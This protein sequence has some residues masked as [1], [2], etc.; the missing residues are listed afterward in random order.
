MAISLD[1]LGSLDSSSSTIFALGALGVDL[2][3]GIVFDFL[4]V[5]ALG[6]FTTHDL[7]VFSGDDLAFRSGNDRDFGSGDDLGFRAKDDSDSSL[8]SCNDVFLPL[9]VVFLL[10]ATT[11]VRLCFRAV[12]PTGVIGP[13]C[14]CYF[15]T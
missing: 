10:G 2:V 14:S 12:N 13:P 9:G 1:I 6:I 11:L 8:F 5:V 7:S 4:P 3:S 15:D